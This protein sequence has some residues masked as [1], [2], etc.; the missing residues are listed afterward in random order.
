MMSKCQFLQEDWTK[1]QRYT[2]RAKKVY[3]EEAQSWQIS[4]IVNL[5]T[6]SYE[7]A[8]SDFDR[9]DKLLPGSPKTT[10]FKGYAREGM[11]KRDDAANH[12]YRYLQ[13]TQQGKEAQYAY[14]RLQEWGYIRQH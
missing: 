11:G 6:K 10:F 7:A 2:K 3:P 4:G 9:Y 12:Y 13:M 5:R 14:Q 1:T 8:Y